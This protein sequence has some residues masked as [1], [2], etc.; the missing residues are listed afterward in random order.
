M[1]ES[2][3]IFNEWYW[4]CTAVQLMLFTDPSYDNRTIAS[5]LKMQIWIATNNW[6]M[7]KWGP[8]HATSHLQSQLESQHP[9][10]PEYAEEWWSSGAIRWPVADPGC[11]SR[12]QRWLTSP[13][14]PRL[15][16]KRSATTLYPSPRPEPAGLLC[17]VI[18]CKHPQHDLPQHQSQPDRCHMPSSCWRLL[19]RYAPSFGSISSQWLRMKAAT[20][21]RCQLYY[22]IKLPELIFL[23]SFKI[24]L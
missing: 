15:G 3:T 9:S 14:R 16:F 8:H 5:T 12:T 17:L 4:R 21:N 24:K 1:S 18:R 20:L 11:G 6:D 2:N 13:K 23:I 10:V 7:P 22:I 19:K